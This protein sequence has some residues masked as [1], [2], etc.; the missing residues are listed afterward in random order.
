MKPI[1][2]LLWIIVAILF[3][4][5]GGGGSGDSSESNDSSSVLELENDDHGDNASTATTL[6]QGQNTKGTIEEE[7]DRDFFKIIIPED[8]WIA[9]FSTTEKGESITVLDLLDT[10]GYRHYNIYNNGGHPYTYSDYWYNEVYI[11]DYIMNY[12]TAGTYYLK[13]RSSYDRIGD[14]SISWEMIEDDHGND[15]TTPTILRQN[16]EI[17]GSIETPDDTDFYKI[18][19]PEDSLLGIFENTTFSSFIYNLYNDLGEKLTDDYDMGENNNFL[20]KTVAAGTYYLE[21]KSY[22]ESGQDYYNH[23]T[24]TGYALSWD[25]IEED[26]HG[27]DINTATI[28]L[29]NLETNGNIETPN[30]I[31]F[32]KID[33]SEDGT[34]ILNIEGGGLV[35]YDESGKLLTEYTR[36]EENNILTK[37]YRVTKGPYYIKV[38]GERG[39]YS[40]NWQ[41]N[42][43]K[44]DFPGA[45]PLLQGQETNGSIELPNE[46]ETFKIEV[47]EDGVINVFSSG[48]TDTYGRFYSETQ[49]DICGDDDNSG[50]NNNFAIQCNV[51][52]GT[53]YLEVEAFDEEQTGEFSVTWQFHIVTNMT[54][55]QGQETNG[56][57]ER[58]NERDIFKIIIPKDGLFNAHIASEID[59]YSDLRSVFGYDAVLDEYAEDNNRSATTNY[60]SDG[61][62]Y[63][64]AGTYY[65]TVQAYDEKETGEYSV[66]WELLPL[67][68]PS[69]I[70]G[71]TRYF[72]NSK[73]DIGYRTYEKYGKYTGSITTKNGTTFT[74][75]GTYDILGDRMTI[76]RTSP[77]EE[78]Y[79]LTYLGGESGR[80][81]FDINSSDGEVFQAYSFGTETS[82][83]IYLN[84]ELECKNNLSECRNQLSCMTNNGHWK[85]GSCYAIVIDEINASNYMP[86]SPV[87]IKIKDINNLI[88]K[89]TTV[90]FN[91]TIELNIT[92]SAIDFNNSSILTLLPNIQGNVSIKL[93]IDDKSMSNEMNITIGELTIPGNQTA[94]EVFDIIIQAMQVNIQSIRDNANSGGY[95]IDETTA[96]N[97]ISDEMALL[98]ELMTDMFIDT[99]E[100]NEKE[101]LAAILAHT[102]A[103]KKLQSQQSILPQDKLMKLNKTVSSESTEWQYI[104]SARLAI[105]I[106]DIFK[107]VNDFSSLSRFDIVNSF[108]ETIVKN[109]GYLRPIFKTFDMWDKLSKSLEFTPIYL[110]KFETIVTLPEGGFYRDEGN[111]TLECI[112][113]FESLDIGE[114][115]ADL[116]IDTAFDTIS[117]YINKNSE[118]GKLTKLAKKYTAYEEDDDKVGVLARLTG[119]MINNFFTS[120]ENIDLKYWSNKLI[121]RMG[122]PKLKITA[123]D[124]EF[125]CG[126]FNHSKQLKGNG[127]VFLLI[128]SIDSYDSIILAGEPGMIN[129]SLTLVDE[130]KE[131]IRLGSHK[132]HNDFGSQIIID[133]V[134]FEVLNHLPELSSIGTCDVMTDQ[135]CRAKCLFNE[136][137]KCSFS[138]NIFDKEGDYFELLDALAQSSNT[139]TY[140]KFENEV[141]FDYSISNDKSISS[142]TIIVN[143]KDGYDTQTISF[144]IDI[145]E[146]ILEPINHVKIKFGSIENEYFEGF[147]TTVELTQIGEPQ[148]Y[149]DGN[150]CDE[151]GSPYFSNSVEEGAVFYPVVT[152]LGFPTPKASIRPRPNRRN[153]SSFIAIKDQGTENEKIWINATKRAWNTNGF[154]WEYQIRYYSGDPK[155]RENTKSLQ[156]GTVPNMDFFGSTYDLSPYEILINDD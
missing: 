139:V 35:L 33:V 85:D 18:I 144:S 154:D 110:K 76:N 43:R 73:G 79:E 87:Q 89:N 67:P 11:N 137:G 61:I 7:N 97:A 113:T 132:D 69:H 112:G 25:V 80:L 131:A 146:L 42:N 4:A 134:E 107:I 105:K 46:K 1:K 143:V 118:R 122:G 84:G 39:E 108:T 22:Y 99:L 152:V 102:V 37:K 20:T 140:S 135:S 28:L 145:E 78:T 104:R 8:S 47:P 53:Y 90:I 92:A 115:L 111:A 156:I 27:N 44:F 3:T 30:D 5:C 74:T 114:K 68:L 150:A 151:R 6:L 77:S 60:I 14:Y 59:T 36:R 19:V 56:N 21:V 117:N 17:H 120:E 58:P 34:L 123:S 63:I 136:D 41:S 128:R 29:Q 50:V 81:N 23:P 31:D 109:N 98:Q 70:V 15:I 45:T 16:Q 64:T 96:M 66:N 83:Y 65:L 142:D 124:I 51:A 125:P 93:K 52:A 86:Y 119:K 72:V 13:I 106:N 148:S 91:D 130:I 57:I 9:Y 126:Y 2:I 149:F 147:P 95:T 141:I 32:Y 54:L 153:C 155:D 40:I 133:S 71:Q 24:S 94:D 129:F 116:L 82:R 38:V 88:E 10:D 62:F 121:S 75:S 100:E 55:P 49:E 103:V 138:I 127:E 12:V 26:D 48:D 101:E